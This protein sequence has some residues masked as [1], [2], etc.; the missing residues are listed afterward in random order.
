MGLIIEGDYHRIGRDYDEP[1]ELGQ[2]NAVVDEYLHLVK[3]GDIGRQLIDEIELPVR[4]RL[5]VKAFCTVIAAEHRPDMR[6]LLIRAG[7]TL[8]QYQSGIGGRICLKPGHGTSAS[9]QRSRLSAHRL[10]AIL[11]TAAAD[12]VRLGDLFLAVVKRSLH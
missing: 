4:K 8:A 9:H 1:D 2:A 5:L 10:E 11:F 7:L 3:E 6:A 12:R